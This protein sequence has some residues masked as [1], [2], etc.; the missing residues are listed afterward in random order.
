M[1]MNNK[2]FQKCEVVAELARGIGQKVHNSHQL[3]GS[4]YSV[5]SI[6]K[7]KCLVSFPS[8]FPDE[9]DIPIAIFSR[10]L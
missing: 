4:V 8:R 10:A 2:S 6:Y 1:K 5:Y 9:C 7:Y 3:E